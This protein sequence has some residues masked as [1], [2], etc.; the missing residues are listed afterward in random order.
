M[1]FEQAYESYMNKHISLRT[2]ERKGRLL[3][4]KL[5][6]EKLFLGNVWWPIKGNLDFLHPEYEIS[7]WRGR[8][9]FIDNAYAQPGS[10]II[11]WEIKGFG[12][13]IREMDRQG[14]SNE[15][16]REF[17]L[18]G[19]GYRLVSL[20]YDDVAERPELVISLLK[21]FLS[22]FQPHTM[23][24]KLAPLAEKEIIRLALRLARPF[25]PVDVSRHLDLNYRTTMKHLNNLL[26]KKW[27]KPVSSGA[28]ERVVYYTLAHGA[29]FYLD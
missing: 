5:H 6:A 11:L 1:N 15:L 16:N 28:G 9:Y 7:D 10:P 18:Q 24:G 13:H 29:T 8:P 25:R 12:T 17:Y 20:A 26:A 3:T 2:G 14:F 23:P 22:Q 4:R 27:I 19:I 21:L